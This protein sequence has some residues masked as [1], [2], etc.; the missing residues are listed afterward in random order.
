MNTVRTKDYQNITNGSMFPE[1][2]PGSGDWTFNKLEKFK[3]MYE[4]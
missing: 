4:F 2:K 3:T 1:I